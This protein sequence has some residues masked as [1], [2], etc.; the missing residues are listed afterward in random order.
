MGR[1]GGRGERSGVGRG[2]WGCRRGRLYG[3]GEEKSLENV[4]IE[5]DS[6]VCEGKWRIGVW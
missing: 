3:N 4:R 6:G 5:G 1:E 2:W